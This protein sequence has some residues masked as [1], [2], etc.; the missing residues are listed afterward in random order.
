M[1]KNSNKI[2][3]NLRNSIVYSNT[4]YYCSILFINEIVNCAIG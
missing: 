4:A 2:C 3:P 1:L